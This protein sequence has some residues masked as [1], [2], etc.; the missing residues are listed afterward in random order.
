MFLSRCVQTSKCV[1]FSSSIVL[2]VL[3]VTL[4][5]NVSAQKGQMAFG[6]T[7][8]KMAVFSAFKANDFVQVFRA[9]TALS[10]CLAWRC[11]IHWVAIGPEWMAVAIFGHLKFK[12]QVWHIWI[13]QAAF[14]TLKHKSES[15]LGFP[16]LFPLKSFYVQNTFWCSVQNFEWAAFNWLSRL[17][18]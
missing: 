8:C 16:F 11:R 9:P 7:V 4:P 5:I 18:F 10:A 13:Y 3:M 15:T 6:A 12:I 1:R 14:Q 17:P 2:L